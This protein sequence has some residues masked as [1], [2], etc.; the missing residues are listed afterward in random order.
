MEIWKDIKGYEGVYQ[1][2]TLG[3]IKGLSRKVLSKKRKTGNNERTI[4]EYIRTPETTKMGY[5]RITL[6]LSGNNIRFFVHRLVCI[7]FIPNPDNKPC[8]NHKNGIKC[9]NNIQN[10]EWVTYSENE[11]HSYNVLKK[12][13][14]KKQLVNKI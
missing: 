12:N 13:A 1:I 10:L 4:S 2:S 3:R 14:K 8:V 11:R 6:S 9:D 7:E 5:Q